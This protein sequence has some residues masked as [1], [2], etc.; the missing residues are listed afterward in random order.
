MLPHSQ[1]ALSILSAALVLGCGLTHA[2]TPAN[3]AKVGMTDS[4][5]APLAAT[6]R[7]A[8]TNVMVSFQASAGGE[9]TNTSGLFAAKTDASTTLQM[10]EMD[11][12]L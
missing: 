9:K 12:K 1:A 11:A 6:K 10:P 7:V 2:Q 3:R 4:T 5:A 8:I